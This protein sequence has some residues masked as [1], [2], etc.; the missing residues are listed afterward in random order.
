MASKKKSPGK[1]AKK[2]P[3]KKRSKPSPKKKTSAKS[4]ISLPD[5]DKLWDY[6]NPAETGK[7]FREILPLAEKSGDKSYL[8]ELLTQIARTE[9]LQ[10]KF[11]EAHK[12]LDKAMKMI[13]AEHIRPRIRYMLERGRTY[14]S[15][16]VFDKA[17]ELFLGAYQ[18]ALKYKEDNYAIDAA[19]M[20]GIVDNGGEAQKWNET[21]I[22]IA[23][24]TNN[25]HARGWLGSLYQNTGWTYHE[26]KE[27]EKAMEVFVKFAK[28]SSERNQNKRLGI[29]RWFI[30]RTLRSLGR[31]EEALSKQIELKKW[32][33]E[34]KQDEDGYVNEEIG[35]CLFALG[36]AGESKEYF[37]KAYEILSKD[38]WLAANEKPRLERLKLLGE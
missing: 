10:R 30:G 28:W 27:Y 8:I 13:K 20:M 6:G 19:H 25:E 32:F 17:R 5:F 1:A 31:N 14:N 21:A 2:K 4:S 9:G 7:K 37:K 33:E 15:S 18:Q 26:M 36:R 3:S 11:D 29:A 12:I 24:E 22:R 38:I 34:T 16:K 35:E 23:E